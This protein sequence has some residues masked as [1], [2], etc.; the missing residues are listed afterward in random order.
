MKRR[1]ERDEQRGG[2]VLVIVAAAMV[3]LLMC[4][5]LAVDVALWYKDQQQISRAAELAAYAGYQ[6]LIRQ[7]LHYSG[8][9]KTA[10][11]DVIREYLRK[12]GVS[13]AEA[14]AAAIELVKNGNIKITLQRQSS[15]F[16]SRFAGGTSV[17]VAG[18]G[19]L[20]RNRL[21]PFAIPEKYND[22]DRDQRPN[23]DPNDP[24]EYVKPP[25]GSYVLGDP[26][27]LLYSVDAMKLSSYD[28]IY[29]P[30]SDG[31]VDIPVGTLSDSGSMAS[32][33]IIWKYPDGTKASG[34]VAPGGVYTL[35]QTPA[36]TPSSSSVDFYK[37]A[38]FRAYG[39]IWDVLGAP[40]DGDEYPWVRWILGFNGG[41][42]LVEKRWLE[43]AG[44]RLVSTTIPGSGINK[45]DY[46]QIIRDTNLGGYKGRARQP[47]DTGV[48]GL[49]LRCGNPINSGEED[50]YKRSVAFL[51]FINR[52]YR[53]GKV[54]PLDFGR[55]TV[56]E[57]TRVQPRIAT[58]TGTPDP[59]TR[60]LSYAG[61]P[62]DAFFSEWD[63]L[64]ADD[65]NSTCQDSY[66]LQDTGIDLTDSD[67]ILA[68]LRNTKG[69]H[70]LHIHHEDFASDVERTDTVGREARAI[71]EAI[72]KFVEDG[73]FLF[74]ACLGTETLEAAL[75]YLEAGA[76]GNIARDY[77]NMTDT[78]A[79]SDFNVKKIGRTAVYLAGT[80]TR[81]D[82]V[83]DV[84]FNPATEAY[85]RGYFQ[86]TDY[87]NPRCQDHKGYAGSTMPDLEDPSGTAPD[88]L[89]PA[90]DSNRLISY[91]GSVSTFAENILRSPTYPSGGDDFES[92]KTYILGYRER[93]D[94]Q[95]GNSII[96]LG[97]KKGRGE[98]AFIGGHLPHMTAGINFVVTEN[99]IEGMWYHPFYAHIPWRIRKVWSTKKAMYNGG[100]GT[101]D[102]DIVI[103][104]R[105][106]LRTGNSRCKFYGYTWRAEES[107]WLS[108]PGW[109]NGR[110]WG[111]YVGGSAPGWVTPPGWDTPPH[112]NTEPGWTTA[113]SWV[114]EPGWG[115]GYWTE[116]PHW[117]GSW[118]GGTWTVSP[119]W[120]TSPGWNTAPYW[121]NDP[122]WTVSPGWYE[123]WVYAAD[124]TGYSWWLAE[125]VGYN[126]EDPE[127]GD[128]IWISWW[129]G[130][131]CS[132]WWDGDWY[133]GDW[134]EG[135]WNGGIWNPGTW[136]HWWDPGTWYRPWDDGTWS[137][138]TW[139]PGDWNPG[140]WNEG[141]WSPGTGTWES[142]WIADWYK[143]QWWSRP[144]GVVYK[145][146]STWIY[147]FKGLDGQARNNGLGNIWNYWFEPMMDLTMQWHKWFQTPYRFAKPRSSSAPPKKYR[148]MEG[149]PVTMMMN[150]DWTQG[151]K[152]TYGWL[153][154][155]TRDELLWYLDN[156]TQTPSD[157]LIE[158]V[159]RQ[160]GRGWPTFLPNLDMKVDTDYDSNGTYSWRDFADT[161]DFVNDYKIWSNPNYYAGDRYLLNNNSWR[162]I[163]DVGWSSW[164]SSFSLL[165]TD[166]G[167]TY[168][169]V[170]PYS[171]WYTSYVQ[172]ELDD[173]CKNLP[174]RYECGMLRFSGSEYYAAGLYRKEKDN[175][176]KT[177][178][179]NTAVLTYD[180]WVRGDNKFKYLFECSRWQ[181]YNYL[182][183]QQDPS[184]EWKPP[185]EWHIYD[186]TIRDLDNDGYSG[187]VYNSIYYLGFPDVAFF[188]LYL[189]NILLG[190]RAA[191]LENDTGRSFNA[192]AVIFDD[193]MDLS[194]YANPTA[195][196]GTNTFVDIMRLGVKGGGVAVG[197]MFRTAPAE[198]ADAVQ[199]G[200]DYMF[201]D[202]EGN[203]DSD[204][205]DGEA[206]CVTWK[207]YVAGQ[208]PANYYRYEMDNG[209]SH[210]LYNEVVDPS[211]NTILPGGE[212]I[213]RPAQ[214]VSVAVVERTTTTGDVADYRK[215]SIYFGTSENLVKVIG[216]ARFF[217]INP[218]IDRL[219][220]DA[221]PGDSDPSVPSD[222]S[223]PSRETIYLG[224]EPDLPGEVRG[225]FLGWEVRPPNP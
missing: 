32:F 155:S 50:F 51:K 10:V 22:E 147:Y 192:G 6:E 105:G 45:S 70:W 34:S 143:G 14:S 5:G 100:N 118:V 141:I 30:M 58:F 96:Y 125:P 28:Y 54:K 80:N 44:Y 104:W 1:F 72:K 222:P 202:F 176:K 112:W 211:T 171:A 160:W 135:D 144:A 215:K 56:S 205:T 133:G 181:I 82:S 71:A 163:P 26:Y 49:Y 65:P 81:S 196:P 66:S 208:A 59:V 200:M 37:I 213:D 214:I 189:D 187:D 157:S 12:N 8:A 119:H 161:R 177:W 55:T 85:E 128:H 86:L 162:N 224:P 170:W 83:A 77:V 84:A 73:G 173:L 136:N 67:A 23:Y 94:A 218:N 220:Y 89:V 61:I 120:N 36:P 209:A 111:Q 11:D 106:A 180:K 124:G 168:Q 93:S 149:V 175:T 225:H 142:W 109:R 179:L 206:T 29:I 186:M 4:A 20:Q 190:A 197:D 114:V 188:R 223:D 159:R 127:T 79:F 69:Y 217:I 95:R 41:G 182:K 132:E 57:E 52:L 156:P 122:G 199:E 98:F 35:Y 46:V 92:G 99:F 126:F 169:P 47:G 110:W 167:S 194:D 107:G 75:A 63:P 151:S 123:T 183:L 48:V 137:S 101:V 16:F 88:V 7:N 31:A 68:F 140:V 203:V 25:V 207:Q 178:Y 113:G 150:G 90:V 64:I 131:W 166:G 145:W 198:L 210:K 195:S 3:M 42:F 158:R 21:A 148:I 134:Y 97:G 13:D 39:I 216:I 117:W 9:S 76:S 201:S 138:G 129:E 139:Y 40:A 172:S 33:N 115:A 53:L 174:T 2:A 146:Q 60:V 153:D 185:I 38:L 152:G 212:F 103:A 15:K 24:N 219:T 78:F 184:W 154:P 18:Q 17:A 193:S 165:S 91:K 74:N 27:I 108:E 221:S 191:E 121:I 19:L 116:D 43:R 130:N 204:P 62:Y 164:W 87:L 102:E